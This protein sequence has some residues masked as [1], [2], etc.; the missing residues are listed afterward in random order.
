MPE[1]I[2]RNPKNEAECS[3][4]GT[5]MTFQN[6]E[7]RAGERMPNSPDQDHRS[8]ITCPNCRKAVDVTSK[9]GATSYESA[10]KQQRDEDYDWI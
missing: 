10:A 2:G 8:V 1:I 6:N 5:Q 9:V 4:C 7:V 3:N